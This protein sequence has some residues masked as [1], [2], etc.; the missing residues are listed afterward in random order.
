MKN[1]LLIE[2]D[3]I[4]GKDFKALLMTQ[5][6]KVFLA[7]N[8]VEAVSY[9]E[10]NIVDVILI[11]PVISLSALIDTKK[12]S[13]WL[14]KGVHGFTLLINLLKIKNASKKKPK[15]ILYS[16]S[17]LSTLREAMTSV[18]FTEDFSYLG[19]PERLEVVIAEI[20]KD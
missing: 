1:V 9:Y 12:K 2:P 15:I 13:N 3:R 17:F 10:N 8:E 18:G 20:N 16:A 11:E 6:M 14:M 5:G 7:E 4:I 19:K